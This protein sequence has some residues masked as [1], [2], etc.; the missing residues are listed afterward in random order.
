MHCFYFKYFSKEEKL[1][2]YFLTSVALGYSN[3]KRLTQQH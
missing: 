2:Y 1:K 3:I